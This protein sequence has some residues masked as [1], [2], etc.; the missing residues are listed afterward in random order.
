MCPKISRHHSHSRSIECQKQQ[1]NHKSSLNLQHI[2]R[3]GERLSLKVCFFL[4]NTM[5]SC[6]FFSFH[7][8]LSQ[9][10]YR[11]TTKL[12]FYSC[13]YQ[14]WWLPGSSWSLFLLRWWQIARVDTVVADLCLQI[15]LNCCTFSN[16]APECKSRRVS[17]RDEKP[18]DE[19]LL[20]GYRNIKLFRNGLVALKLFI[21]SYNN[22]C[23]ISRFFTVAFSTFL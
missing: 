9:E 16:V 23:S 18:L 1:S 12:C 8:T 4:N 6:T 15:S 10:D 3:Y 14:H 21:F 20:S 11:F 7:S 19:F 2:W 5:T 17:Y 22:Y 13:L